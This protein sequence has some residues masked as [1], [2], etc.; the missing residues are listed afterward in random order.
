MD[1]AAYLTQHKESYQNMLHDVNLTNKQGTRPLANVIISVTTK[2][3]YWQLVSIIWL[4]LKVK[5]SNSNR[6]IQQDNVITCYTITLYFIR[7]TNQFHVNKIH[8]LVY[9][10]TRIHIQTQTYKCI[11]M[12]CNTHRLPLF[13]NIFVSL[14]KIVNNHIFFG[15]INSSKFSFFA[16]LQS[17]IW[18]SR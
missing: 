12:Q 17:Y 11:H 1:I 8:V 9:T 4:L 18:N 13:Y 14:C 16:S 3:S 15:F 10:Y 6:F 5:D 7:Q 2:Q